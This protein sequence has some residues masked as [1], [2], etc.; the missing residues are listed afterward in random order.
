MNT[1]KT[2]CNDYGYDYDGIV[3]DD[4]VYK[5]L[6]V[7]LSKQGKILL[8]VIH[9]GKPYDYIRHNGRIFYIF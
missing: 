3:G 1:I 7:R 6:Y 9:K 4:V 8:R 5:K 2:L